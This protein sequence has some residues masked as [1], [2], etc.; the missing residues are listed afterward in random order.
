MPV[1]I[2]GDSDVSSDVT[3]VI[4][5][6]VGSESSPA[7]L[8]VVGVSD[9][10]DVVPVVTAG[11]AAVVMRVSVGGLI[12]LTVDVGES[13]SVV[14]VSDCKDVVPVVTAGVAT[15]VVMR[16]SVG[17]LITLT[18]D[19]GE[20]V[21][22]ASGGAII[23]SKE[24]LDRLARALT[25]KRR[26]Q[27]NL[28]RDATGP[29]G[30]EGS[31]PLTPVAKKVKTDTR[32]SPLSREQTLVNFMNKASLIESA[33]GACVGR[34]V[35]MIMLKKFDASVTSWLED[36]CSETSWFEDVRSLSA[37]VGATLS[38]SSSEVVSSSLSSVRDEC[39]MTDD[40]DE[41]QRASEFDDNCATSRIS[42][43]GVASQIASEIMSDARLEYEKAYER[44]RH[45][46]KKKISAQ[47]KIMLKMLKKDFGRAKEKTGYD[48]A[49]VMRYV[50]S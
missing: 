45:D 2:V 17:G 50:N 23:A 28:T 48:Y 33:D 40:V 26:F 46:V 4:S 14:G 13:L 15:A 25:L 7:S 12:T 19:V 30:D 20:S 22:E 41:L 44:V 38:S 47:F 24:R 42:S 10:K 1:V 5:A 31:H 6:V 39:C 27:T 21:E 37:P 32:P 18:V 49:V 43:S 34:R 11:V 9:V 16:V 8:S 3:C 29:P 35:A 36:N